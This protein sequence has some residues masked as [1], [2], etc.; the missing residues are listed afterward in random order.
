MPS[1]QLAT[2]TLNSTLD[3]VVLIPDLAPG[4]IYNVKIV[5]TLAGGK[6]VNVA[7][8]AHALGAE[9]MVTGLVAGPCGRWICTLLEQEGIPGRFVSLDQG[10]SRISTIL[11]DPSR[12][13]TTVINDLGPSVLVGRWVSIRLQLLQIVEGYPWVALCGSGLPG[14]PDSVYADLCADIQAH[15]QRVCLDARGP[16]LAEALAAQPYLVKCNQDE[17]AQ[18]AGFPIHGPP[19]ALRAAWHWLGRGV[20][21]VM[22]TLG[23][24]GA[25]ATEGSD[26]WYIQAP[27]VKALC[28]IGSGDAA[29]AG[30][31]AGMARGDPLP[32]AARLGVA[33]GAANA[34]VLGSG[35]CALDALPDLM[36]STLVRPLRA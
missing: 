14:L 29:L 19:E 12:E 5:V 32:V 11:V 20:Q 22:I 28:P 23:E 34:L 7:R 6:G 25:I 17:A 21:R 24:Q 36:R 4:E 1:W 13:Q 26:A 8:A 18:V 16:W 33:V 15:G 30:L 31:I 27:R 3:R 10:D 35:R 2:V 9:L